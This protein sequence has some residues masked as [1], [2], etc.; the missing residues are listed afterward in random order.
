MT[1]DQLE[2]EA[3]GWLASVGYSP[4]NARDLDNLDLRLAR[5]STRVCARAGDTLVLS[6]ISQTLAVAEE[7]L[8]QG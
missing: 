2:Q 4:L 5:A 3:L 1:E 6:G 7:K 8:L